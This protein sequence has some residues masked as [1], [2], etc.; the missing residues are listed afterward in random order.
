MSVL[1][2]R[3]PLPKNIFVK[4]NKYQDGANAITRLLRQ[5]GNHA[6]PSSDEHDTSVRMTKGNMRLS[7]QFDGETHIDDT[8]SNGR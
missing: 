6:R 2:E 4:K 8:R 7:I 1:I 3:G 5:C